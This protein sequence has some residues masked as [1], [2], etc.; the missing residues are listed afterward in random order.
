MNLL[1][2]PECDAPISADARFCAIC[3]LRQQVK[4][5][6]GDAA[7]GR[8]AV[9][10]AQPGAAPTVAR[11]AR[12]PRRTT[13]PEDS[14][15]GQLLDQ[16]F[17]VASLIGEG[18]FGR[19]YRAVE[20]ATRRDVAVKVLDP[21]ATKNASVVARFHRETAVLCA[22]RDEHTCTMLAAG[23]AADGTLYLV[24]ELLEGR[25]LHQVFHEEAPLPWRRVCNLLGQACSALAEAHGHGLVHGDLKPENVFLVH[26]SKDTDFVKVLDAGLVRVM[27]SEP[28]VQPSPRRRLYGLGIGALEH[29]S[30]EQISFAPLDGRSDIYALG[31]L[32][33][34]LLAG[35]LPF[36]G[37]NGVAGLIP[38]LTRAPA[39]PSSHAPIPR[40]VDQ[41]ILRCLER[42]KRYRYP[43][44]TQL[45]SALRE[46]AA[47][48]AP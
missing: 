3:G 11:P 2:C 42:D 26:R 36:V 27:Q 20:L 31:V 39:P 16:R 32:G 38:T 1:R 22:L 29:L 6:A 46:L 34:E 8:P 21:D 48:P 10:A 14:L 4:R 35:R 44:V 12:A 23:Q 43:D 13:P 15:C 30:P 19:V 41:V 28:R 17:Q 9:P 18:R 33:Y 7:A 24:N 37:A 45:A 47:A 40:A 5:P 25:S